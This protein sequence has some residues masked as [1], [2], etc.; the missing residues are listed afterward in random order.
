MSAIK[1]FNRSYAMTYLTKNSISGLLDPIAFV[2]KRNKKWIIHHVLKMQH[3]CV[4]L[5]LLHTGKLS[6]YILIQQ[7]INVLMARQWKWVLCALPIA[8]KCVLQ[9]WR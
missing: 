9:H 2:Q 4:V 6:L 8:K 7:T 3:F 1:N 5:K